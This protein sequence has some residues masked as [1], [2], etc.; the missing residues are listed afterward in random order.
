MT[1]DEAEAHYR[2]LLEDRQ[3]VYTDNRAFLNSNPFGTDHDGHPGLVNMN[4][5]R[6]SIIGPLNPAALTLWKQIFYDD[7][8]GGFLGECPSIVKVLVRIGT[9]KG[10]HHGEKVLDVTDSLKPG[11]AIATFDNHGKFEGHA[12]IYIRKGLN[13]NG[14]PCIW[15]A[16][17][18]TPQ[19]THS[20]DGPFY[21]KVRSL[22][23]V[24]E[25]QVDETDPNTANNFY[26]VRTR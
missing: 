13:E 21:P 12:A 9:T 25:S 6:R 1:V 4:A 19:D 8:A 11:T 24:S 22:R 20:T 18:F 17:Q 7:G 15:V 5:Q 2:R 10:W 26:V 23:I 16:D 3:K 14:Q